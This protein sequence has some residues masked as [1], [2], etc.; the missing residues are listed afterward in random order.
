MNEQTGMGL[1]T[2]SNEVADRIQKE[3]AAAMGGGKR[4]KY[5]RFVLAALGRK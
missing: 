5:S 1:T 4:K 3:L 2:T